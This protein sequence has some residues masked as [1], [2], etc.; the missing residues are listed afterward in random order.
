VR[1]LITLP[2]VIDLNTFYFRRGNSQVREDVV[3]WVMAS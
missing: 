3:E 2:G 1:P